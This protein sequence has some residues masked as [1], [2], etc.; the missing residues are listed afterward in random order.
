MGLS[1]SPH[2]S[3][4]FQVEHHGRHRAI[5]L[6]TSLEMIITRLEMIIT[7]LVMTKTTAGKVTGITYER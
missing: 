6:I 2:P 7:R 3:A 4:P 1:P 5:N